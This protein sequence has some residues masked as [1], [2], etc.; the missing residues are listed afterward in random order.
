M[1]TRSRRGS[2][3]LEV[4]VRATD[5]RLGQ[6]RARL[7]ALG[8]ALT[9]L[10][11]IDTY[12]VVSHG[13]L[14]LRESIPG[15]GRPSAELIAYHRPDER[16]ARW[17]TYQRIPVDP[18]QVASLLAALTATLGCRGVV[19]KQRTIAIIGR[20]RIHLDQVAGLGRF[21]ELE[22]VAGD[23]DDPLAAGEL[24][25]VASSLG[26][27]LSERELIAGSYSDLLGTTSGH[28]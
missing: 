11:Q 22:T 27:T 19:D 16:G 2:R 20:T 26:M 12:L 7:D 14:K 17:S 25:A 13:R 9:T 6:V 10:R 23:E 21:I 3:N 8:A 15:E 18:A 1:Q 5:V 28:Q 4:K 24:A